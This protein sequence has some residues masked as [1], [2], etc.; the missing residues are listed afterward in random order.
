MSINVSWMEHARCR[1]FPPET[2]YP[3]ATGNGARQAI[4]RAISICEGC[5]VVKDCSDHAKKYAKGYGI[6]GAVNRSSRPRKGPRPI[7]HG[8]NGGY[9]AHG[10]R[11]EPIC[12]PCRKAHQEYEQALTARKKTP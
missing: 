5:P 7:R 8:T 2:W 9:K 4:R 11:D 3:N 12:P 1:E 10:R 6:W